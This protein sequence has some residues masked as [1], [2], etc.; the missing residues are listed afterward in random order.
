[1]NMLLPVISVCLKTVRAFS[2]I[3]T[4]WRH[5]GGPRPKSFHPLVLTRSSQIKALNP[6]LTAGAENPSLQYDTVV[7]CC[8]RYAI[9]VSL[10]VSHCRTMT[11][12]STEQ[13]AVFHPLIFLSRLPPCGPHKQHTRPYVNTVTRTNRRSGAAAT[14][15][16]CLD[17]ITAVCCGRRPLE[18]SRAAAH[19]SSCQQESFSSFFTES[20]TDGNS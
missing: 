9:A 8:N 3:K 5:E 14:S 20:E 12:L 13:M 16:A 11:G 7:I 4:A 18:P 17:L 15:A 10:Q 1:M 2:M 19:P 6:S